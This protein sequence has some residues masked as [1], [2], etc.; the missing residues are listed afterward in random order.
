[1]AQR[2]ALA[3]AHARNVSTQEEFARQCGP[4]ACAQMSS[5]SVHQEAVAE[6]GSPKLFAGSS[7]PFSLL[8][9]ALFKCEKEIWAQRGALAYAHAQNMSTQE[10]LARQCG[11]LA[12]EQ[13][14]STSV[15]QEAVAE[16]GS[17]ELS[18]GSSSPLSL[19]HPALLKCEKG[20]L[21]QRGALA[22]AHARYVST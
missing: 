22:C 17:P 6:R 2:G 14:N 4:L 16:R 18:A 12:C 8:H 15:H 5:T 3:C 10:E 9:P 11:P 21:A 13:M 7:T 19:L 20:I 1:M